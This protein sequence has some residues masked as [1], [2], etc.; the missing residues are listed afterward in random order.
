[1]RWPSR[2]NKAGSAI[3]AISPS[4][5]WRSGSGNNSPGCAE[6]LISRWNRNLERDH[7]P[8]RCAGALAK[9]MLGFYQPQEGG[10]WLDGRISVIWRPMN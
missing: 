9:L 2:E 7:G 3:R 1:M 10:I 4:A 8:L 5:I 6:Y